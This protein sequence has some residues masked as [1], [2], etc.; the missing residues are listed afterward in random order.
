MSSAD[1]YASLIDHLYSDDQPL[2]NAGIHIGGFIIV[3]HQMH[4]EIGYWINERP[5]WPTERYVGHLVGESRLLAVGV[6]VGN[7]PAE[8]LW[9]RLMEAPYEITDCQHPELI[10]QII[11]RLREQYR[12]N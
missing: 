11:D 10:P 3:G 2:Q 9:D 1:S 6:A 7:T 4:V 8:L 5:D 12:P